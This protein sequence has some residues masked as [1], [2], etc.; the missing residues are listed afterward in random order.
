MPENQE[1]YNFDLYRQ[2]RYT[3]EENEFQAQK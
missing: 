2:A 3:L 1:K